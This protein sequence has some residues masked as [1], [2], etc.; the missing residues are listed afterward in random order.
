M[1]NSIEI[2]QDRY[3]I[4]TTWQDNRPYFSGVWK[5]LKAKCAG[6]GDNYA[7]IS[8]L[9]KDVEENWKLYQPQDDRIIVR[10]PKQILVLYPSE[11]LKCVVADSDI[12]E[13]ALRRGKSEARYRAQER[14]Y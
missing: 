10:L 13:K 8:E 1:N 5:H 4:L 2:L 14:R 12:Y 9:M 6:G 7:E 3:G 11:I